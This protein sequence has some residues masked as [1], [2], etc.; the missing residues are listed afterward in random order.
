LFKL[1]A[2][3][4]LFGSL[5]A[6]AASAATQKPGPSPE[7]YKKP[8]YTCSRIYYV[9]PKGS[10][11]SVGSQ[12]NPWK[13]LQG[14]NTNLAALGS[15][16]PGVCV[17]VQ[18][19]KYDGVQMSVGGNY[20]SASGYLTYRCTALDACIIKG[21]AGYHGGESFETVW[22]SV[23]GIPP[24]YIQIDGF[25]MTGGNDIASADG[26]TITN[27]DNGTEIGSHHIWVLNSEI[28]GFGQSGAAVAATEY[29]Y[30]IHNRV[31]GNSNLNC[32]AQGSGLAFNIM[33]A[34]PNY[35]PTADDRTNPNPLL[36]PTWVI[37][38]SFFHIVT[39]WNI[40]YNNALTQCG[41]QNTPYDTDGNG[42]IFDTNLENYV[43]G[44]NQGNT[45][46]YVSPSLVAFN[47]VYNNG[48]GGMHFYLSA[49]STVANNSCFNNYLD[50]A[51]QGSSRPCI[52]NQQGY[53]FSFI[54][55]IAVA[56]PASHTGNCFP[57]T[58]PYTGYNF[59]MLGAPSTPTLDV[60]SNNITRV[61]G[62][63]CTGA[64]DAMYNGDV[65]TCAPGA[66][67]ANQCA[68]DPSW[69]AVGNTSEG[70]E[71]TPPRG[72]N[73]ALKPGSPAIGKGL[74]ESYLPASAIDVGACSSSLTVCH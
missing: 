55:N 65:F 41:T 45:Q 9:A 5:F 74:V 39:S 34:I 69:V 38:S 53:G 33:H 18:P 71:T 17:Y 13:T 60:F 72:A 37:G 59:A 24:N 67:P 6:P 27:G 43:G 22:P 28:S 26:V 50:P 40:V 14:A 68:T 31:H 15:T 3:S 11:G 10:D 2:A 51:D 52:D 8:Y 16:A 44:V 56:I 64:E 36:G 46:N 57:V 23:G 29:I 49:D 42:I 73:F 32:G 47:V 48:G 62:M 58:P 35:T 12:S 66:P 21:D 4:L 19:G 54:S 20:A 30:M 63:S 61:I 1:I 7:L 25:V 70:S